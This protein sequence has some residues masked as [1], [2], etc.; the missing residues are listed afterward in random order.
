MFTHANHRTFIVSQALGRPAI[1]LLSDRLGRMNVAGIGTLIASV[2]AFFLWIFAGKYYAGLIIY[3]LFGA[4]AGILWPCVGPVAAEVV[5]LQLLPAAL[6]VYW[7]ILVF[8][9]TL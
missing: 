2:A 3:A 7:I 8:P 9:A 5:G 6:S 4:V 1:G